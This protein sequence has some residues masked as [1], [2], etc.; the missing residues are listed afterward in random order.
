MPSDTTKIRAS[1]GCMSLIG[2]GSQRPVSWGNYFW[3]SE[4]EG[5]SLR[6]LNMWAENLEEACKRFLPDGMVMVATWR[7]DRGGFAIIV[8]ERIPKDWLYQKLCFTGGYGP[9]IQQ[10]RE[11]YELVGDPDNELEQFTDPVAY[12]AKRGGSYDP[13]TGV[14]RYTIPARSKPLD[15]KWTVEP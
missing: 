9:S 6:C 14:I 10:A 7:G 8:D 5:R 1:I 12:Y 15:T 11:M 2:T 3:F 13:K 4:D